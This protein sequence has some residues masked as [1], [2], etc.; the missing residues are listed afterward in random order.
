MQNYID[1]GSLDQLFDINRG[2]VVEEW[3]RK[4]KAERIAVV[5]ECCWQGPFDAK[6][7]QRFSALHGWSF[8][9]PGATQPT[10]SQE[11]R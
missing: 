4:V 6:L 10:F 5:F 8:I 9:G 7:C 2:N 1:S 3:L 11:L